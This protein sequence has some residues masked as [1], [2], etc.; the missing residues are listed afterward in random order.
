MDG[1]QIA[2]FGASSSRCAGRLPGRLSF[3]REGN[4]LLPAT[5]VGVIQVAPLQAPGASAVSSAPWLRCTAPAR[6]AAWVKVGGLELS[7]MRETSFVRSSEPAR[8]LSQEPPGDPRAERSDGAQRSGRQPQSAGP[9]LRPPAIAGL[10]LCRRRSEPQHDL[11]TGGLLPPATGPVAGGY[12]RRRRVC[13]SCCSIRSM[14]A[15]I[16]SRSSAG[17]R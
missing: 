8:R 1:T 13:R 2:R 12:L 6:R 11:R 3:L 10:S 14:S 4:C 15:S 9:G 16:A 7:R 17:V 5:G